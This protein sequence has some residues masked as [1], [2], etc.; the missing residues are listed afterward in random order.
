MKKKYICTY[1]NIDYLARG[2]A[3]IDSINKHN[4]DVLI[5]VLA[6]DQEV[7]EYF[8]QG[9]RNVEVIEMRNYQLYNEKTQSIHSDRKQFFFSITANFCRMLLEIKTEIDV[10]LY[11]DA[12]V[13]VTSDITPIYREFESYSVGVCS[14]RR[15]K[16][17]EM[18]SKNYGL[19]NVGVNLFRNDRVG[20]RCLS[21]WSQECNEWYP[22]MPGYDLPF[23]SDQI[24]LDK[25]PC[26]YK[27]KFLEIKNIGVNVAPWNTFNQKFRFSNDNLYIK[28]K[29]VII[30]HFS[31]LVQEEKGIWNPN[32]G[33]AIFVLN[34]P[35]KRFYIT[36]IKKL[37]DFGL[38]TEK[39]VKLNFRDSLKKRLFF[40][41]FSPFLNR[42]IKVHDTRE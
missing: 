1:F 13:Y 19:Y 24:F 3:L 33:R 16:Y 22:G 38:D 40:L 25:W 29:K 34:K 36:Y 15:N 4:S 30:Y 26:L 21:E 11:L 12:D 28:N 9:Y 41:I 17:I 6:I 27:K 32:S 18:V 20:R 7:E 37:G 8:Q 39:I 14:H 31:S 35:L 5:Y 2:L 23:F 10:L 42:K